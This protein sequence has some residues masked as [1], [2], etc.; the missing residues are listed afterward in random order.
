[1]RNQWPTAQLH[2][3]SYEPQVKIDKNMDAKSRLNLVG[4][5]G[6]DTVNDLSLP[7]SYQTSYLL[8]KILL[9]VTFSY[10]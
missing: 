5:R 2:S 6:L 10:T 1:M 4:L 9:P 8:W 3:Q 7:F